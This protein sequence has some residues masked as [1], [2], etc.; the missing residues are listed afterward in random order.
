MPIGISFAEEAS[1]N[2]ATTN[3]GPPTIHGQASVTAPTKPSYCPEPNTLSKDNKTLDWIAPNNWK[4]HDQSFVEQ[5]AQFTGAHW[6]GAEIGQVTCSYNGI[7]KYD[8]P[9]LL[10]NPQ[11]VLSPRG[12]APWG[13]EI[14]G[15]I[16]CLS[17]KV[18]DCPFYVVKQTYGPT[19]LNALENIKKVRN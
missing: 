12:A 6:N 1:S 5:I 14:N 13:K 16:N 9:I 2:N 7:Q 18:T 10:Y 15:V 19:D 11:F 3:A 4:S 8:F 17:D